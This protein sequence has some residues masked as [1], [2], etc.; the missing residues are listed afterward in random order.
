MQMDSAALARHRR[1]LDMATAEIRRA[2]PGDL[3]RPSP[4][5]GWDLRALLEHMV[6]QNH[7][8]ADAVADGEAPVAA[9]APRSF[10]DGGLLPDWDASAER[11]AAAFAAAPGEREVLLVEVSAEQRFPV[12]TVLGFHLLDSVVHA[13][14]VATALAHPFRPDDDLVELVAAQAALVPGGPARERPGAAFAPGVP[15]PDD[16]D[17][18]TLALARLGRAVV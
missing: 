3:G 11:V 7:G 9:F 1:A 17:P 10:D 6:G 13:W 18:W 14:D 15:V 2:G 4:C 12:G 5:V 8:F 16:A